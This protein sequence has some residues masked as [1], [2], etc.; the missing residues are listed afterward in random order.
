MP[1]PYALLYATVTLDGY[2]D[3]T[4]PERPLLSGPAD[5]L[6]GPGAASADAILVGAG[7]IRADNPRL[8]VNS[9]ERRAARTAAEGRSTRSRSPSA[10]AASWTRRRG[11]GTRAGRRCC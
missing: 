6:A 2:L 9:A 7:T 3:D 10:A 5:R 8:L 4:G 1:V 11:S